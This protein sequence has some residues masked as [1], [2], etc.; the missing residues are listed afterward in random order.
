MSPPKKKKQKRKHPNRV[1]LSRNHKHH[2]RSRS[3]PAQSHLIRPRRQHNHNRRQHKVPQ[4][5]THAH[6]SPGY[7]PNRAPNHRRWSKASFGHDR[8]GICFG[9]MDTGSGNTEAKLWPKRSPS[10]RF[11]LDG[12]LYIL[13]TVHLSFFAICVPFGGNCVMIMVVSDL[14]Q[15]QQ[16]QT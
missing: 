1:W 4:Q 5:L 6:H 12:V 3:Q 10:E 13:C 2:M 7:K 16:Q 14:M 15:Q 11:I 8:L 9:G